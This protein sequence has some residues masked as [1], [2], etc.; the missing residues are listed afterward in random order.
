MGNLERL[1]ELHLKDRVVTAGE[2]YP[3][4]TGTDFTAH[5]SFPL[6]DLRHAPDGSVV[7][8]ATT[9]E[10]DPAA[11][12]PDPNRPWFWHYPGRKLTQYWRK[13]PGTFDETL[14]ATVNARACYWASEWP[15]PG[16]A[17]FENFELN[18]RFSQGQ[19]VV[20]GL[21]EKEAEMLL[22]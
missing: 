15:I 17:A 13:Y 21:T 4:F 16:G 6:G 14:R 12:L 7:I 2:L 20:F 10:A 18:E 19:T 8:A 5:T 9:D 11:T 3:G 22:R 1:R